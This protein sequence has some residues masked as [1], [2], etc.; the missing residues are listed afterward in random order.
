MKTLFLLVIMALGGDSCVQ[1]DY[2]AVCPLSLDPNMV[3]GAVLCPFPAD[4][5][6]WSC[7]AGKF[8]RTAAYED[9]QGDYPVNI[10]S[11]DPN[12]TVTQDRD[13]KTW[14]IAADLSPGTHYLVVTAVDSPEWRHALPAERFV[15]VM[16]E[17]TPP[18][19]TGPVLH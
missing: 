5:N 9:C 4:P 17:A 8:N 19:N 6:V 16:V 18:E 2:S 3:V 15:T 14:T 10:T 11:A 7:E 13:A 12:V 1:P